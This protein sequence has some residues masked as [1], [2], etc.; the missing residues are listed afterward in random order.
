MLVAV[1]MTDRIDRY[2]V[3]GRPIRHTVSPLVHGLF[4]EQTGQAMTYEVIEGPGSS[5]EFAA[6]VRAFVADG[7]KGMNVTAPFKADAFA[8]AD[9]V[10][11][12]AQLSGAANTLTFTADGRIHGD[13]YDGLALCRDIEVNL[14]QPLAGRRL[15]LLGAGGAARAS[16]APFVAAGPAEFVVVN[17]TVPK[18]VALAELAERLGG[19]VLACS[20]DALEGLGAFDVVVNATSAS[21]TGDLPPVPTGSFD[22]AGLAYD[23]AYGRGLTPFLRHAQAAGVGRLADG[24]GMLVEQAADAFERWRGVRPRTGAVIARLAARND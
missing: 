9:E 19:A 15:L 24:T 23:L 7:G 18:A 1:A 14:E 20:Y 11:E 5:R 4:A 2:A 13:T 12:R 6:I 8:L 21:L 17:S 16:I 3:I 10:S 22:P